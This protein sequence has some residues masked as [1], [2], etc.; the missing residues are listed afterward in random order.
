MA[1]ISILHV[2]AS[3]I[4]G[5]AARAAYRI[6]Q[7]IAEHGTDFGL[8]SRMRVIDKFSSDTTVVG[9]IPLGH[10]R[11]RRIL[12]SRMNE[13]GRRGFRTCNPVLHS[14]AWPATGLGRELNQRHSDGL[15]DLLHLH[16]LGDSTLSIEEVGRSSMSTVWTIHDQWAFCG[17]E[18]YTNLPGADASASIAE[19]FV[20]GYTPDSR[21]ANEIGPD[22]NRLTWRRKKRAWKRPIHIVCPSQW[23]A[24]CVMRSALMHDWP[25]SVIPNPIDVSGWSPVGKHHARRVLGLPQ[26]KHMLLFGA[27][28]GTNDPRKGADLLLEALKALRGLLDARKAADIELLVF[29]QVR[30]SRAPESSFPIHYFG[31]LQDD[32]SLKVLYSAADAMV[33]PSRQDN[34]P[35]TGLEAL[36]CGI[37]IVAFNTGGLPDIIDHKETGWLAKPF[38]VKD[39]ASGLEW[40]L[41]DEMRNRALGER[42]RVVA[43]DRF[44]PAKVAAKYRDVYFSCLAYNTRK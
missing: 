35:N 25:V 13:W 6:H 14:T 20:T 44:A 30:P 42:A 31:H 5:G 16:W 11:L 15:T 18:H 8:D 26:N 17:A 3:D 12:R 9:G 40:I 27:M 34:L 28:G 2:N 29:G 1:P 43:V 41:A 22:L 7:S 21:P 32:I 39:F 33:I 19:R 37:P 38:D 24:N 36:A 23:L 10:G 4:S